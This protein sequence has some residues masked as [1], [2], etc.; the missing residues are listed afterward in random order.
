M[1]SLIVSTPYDQTT[2][3]RSAFEV[4]WVPDVHASKRA[5]APDI[6]S[7]RA[8]APCRKPRRLSRPVVTPSTSVSMLIPRTLPT[9]TD[10]TVL[11]L[12]V[13]LATSPAV[14]GRS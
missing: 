4:P 10:Y 11:L 9:C 12:L 5:T 7:P 2:K 1:L 14:A 13:L 6:E 3:V 8:T